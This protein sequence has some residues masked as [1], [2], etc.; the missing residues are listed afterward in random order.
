MEYLGIMCQGICN[1]QVVQKK[2]CVC[3]YVEREKKQMCQNVDNW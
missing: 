1:F 3:V 2:N